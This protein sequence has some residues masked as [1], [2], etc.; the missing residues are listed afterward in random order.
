MAQRYPQQEVGRNGLIPPSPS[1]AKTTLSS[2]YILICAY[3][4]HIHR[5]IIL[6]FLWTS[7]KTLDALTM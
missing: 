3:L 5:C 2:I 4:Q 7:H 6:S 1:F